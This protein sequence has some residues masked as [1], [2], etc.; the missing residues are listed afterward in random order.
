MFGRSKKGI[1]GSIFGKKKVEEDRE[2]FSNLP[3]EKRK[4]KLQAKCD[5][6]NADIA[7]EQKARD[8]SAKL[9]DGMAGMAD[10]TALGEIQKQIDESDRKIATLNGELNKFT[11]W[12][13]ALGGEQGGSMRSSAS[14]A[15]IASSQPEPAAP[16]QQQYAADDYQDEFDDGYDDQ[17]A[18]QGYDQG[19]YDQG[20]YD[21][22]A[23][24]GG[25][26]SQCR[27][28]YD[29]AGENDTE[30]AIAAGEVLDVLEMPNGGW[31]RVGR[32][33][34][35]GYVPETYVSFDG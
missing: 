30:L 2:D 27:A 23:G 13:D 22:G 25:G 5:E 4:R 26:G 12:L 3:P 32:G 18:A 31:V 17:G 1:G 11:L 33:A 9:L 35:S 34:E 21:Q 29:F 28:L 7:K 19:G 6:I 15:S 8:G 24:G 20:G 14:A 10:Q 16:V